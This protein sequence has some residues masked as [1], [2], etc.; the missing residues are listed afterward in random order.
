MNVLLE[1]IIHLTLN[2]QL[3]I[4]YEADIGIGNDSM[5]SDKTN[6]GYFM[7][8]KRNEASMCKCAGPSCTCCVDVH[9][10]ISQKQACVIL[11]VS[12]KDYAINLQFKVDGRVVSKVLTINVLNM[13]YC[14]PLTTITYCFYVPKYVWLIDGINICPELVE[15]SSFFTLAI[16]KLRCLKF[17]DGLFSVGH[18]LCEH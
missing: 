17:A 13:K 8:N 10:G 1:L 9:L 12:L 11:T 4:L 18:K 2:I 3:V 15:K 6:I 7:I 5:V 14:A 16:H